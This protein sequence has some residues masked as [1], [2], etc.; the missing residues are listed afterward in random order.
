MHLVQGIYEQ[1]YLP[2]HNYRNEDNLSLEPL[3]SQPLP[4]MDSPGEGPLEPPMG[5]MDAKTEPYQ[6]PNSGCY[7]S[8]F[9]QYYGGGGGTG[10][11]GGGGGDS[12]G[13]QSPV[14][15]NKMPNSMYD[16]P[17]SQYMDQG[18]THPSSEQYRRQN[19]GGESSNPQDYRRIFTEDQYRMLAQEEEYRNRRIE[20]QY[21]KFATDE[22]YRKF[23]TEEHYRKL[24]SEEQYRRLASLAASKN[25]RGGLW[26][27]ALH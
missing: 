5:I 19:S 17:N 25:E 11:S 2:Q 18:P 20:E 3:P 12:G 14:H 24:A 15:N 26:M 22:Q 7:L 1:G 13:Y 27:P 16:H 10:G 9:P 23:A 4:H 8:N 6:D 21:R